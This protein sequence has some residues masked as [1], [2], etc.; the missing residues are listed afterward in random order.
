MAKRLDRTTK[1]IPRRS[2]YLYLKK[3]G[4]SESKAFKR[5]SKLRQRYA[6][7]IFELE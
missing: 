5:K 7:A 3:Y 4:L 1:R 6:F 2:W